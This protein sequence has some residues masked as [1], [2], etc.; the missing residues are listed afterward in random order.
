MMADVLFQ[1][2]NKKKKIAFL[3]SKTSYWHKK[4]TLKPPTVVNFRWKNRHSY[5]PLT[6]TVVNCRCILHH[7]NV[8]NFQF[9]VNRNTCNKVQKHTKF[10][11]TFFLFGL[12][13]NAFFFFFIC[14][15]WIYTTI[16]LT[17]LSTYSVKPLFTRTTLEKSHFIIPLT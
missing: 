5:L 4:I 16:T 9:L 1:P 2:S 6:S 3:T 14:T 8:E 12:K 13:R 10:T 11:Q 15:V 7:K 17:N